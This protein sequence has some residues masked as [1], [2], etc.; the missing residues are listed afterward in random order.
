MRE[1]TAGQTRKPVE[2]RGRTGGQS[3]GVQAAAPSKQTVE[4]RRQSIESIVQT[5]LEFNLVDKIENY[6]FL[7]GIKSD[8]SICSGI[9]I[10]NFK[11]M[12]T[13][14][15]M[16]QNDT[17]FTLILGSKNLNEPFQV[18][19]IT[20]KEIIVHPAYNKQFPYANDIAIIQLKTMIK[21]GPK[22]GK[23]DVV[24]KNSPIKPG[25]NVT[26]LAYL[27]NRLRYINSKIGDFET[28]RSSYREINS[29]NPQL[30]M[31][32][33]FCITLPNGQWNNTYEGGI[34]D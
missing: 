11:I 15:C 13:A 18:L 19:N 12:T 14:Q 24:A 31:E 2:T 21:F 20:D 3:V 26:M 30:Q 8:Q 28:C 5:S 6:K 23:L 7:V 25:N 9:I 17:K 16:I 32:Q 33:Q 1:Q 22:V 4:P 29:D 34:F 27:D 10:T